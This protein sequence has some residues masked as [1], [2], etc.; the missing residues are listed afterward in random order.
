MN[1][2]PFIHT[3]L[4]EMTWLDDL[5]W[6]AAFLVLSIGAFLLVRWVFVFTARKLAARTRTRFDDL[7]VEKGVVSAVALFAPAIVIRQ[8]R[9]FF[10]DVA[11]PVGQGLTLYAMFVGVLLL[12]R[13]L[14][15]TNAFY[16]TFP[17]ARRRPIRGPV[18]LIKLFLYLITAVAAA[19]F[20]LGKS[21]WAVVSGI[22]AMTALVILIFKDTILSFVA[23]IQMAAYD[24]LRLG[25]WVEMPSFGADGDVID[26]SLNTVQVQNFDKTV[27]SIPAHKF[28]DHSFRNWRGM[29]E[30]GGRRIKRAILIDQSSI[31]FVN[32]EMQ[33]SFERMERI[34]EYMRTRKR[35]I[36]EH[37]AYEETDTTVAVNG[38]RMTNLG[39]FRA[40]VTAYLREN[41]KLRQDLTFM[42]RHLAP[43]PEGLPLEVYVFAAD[44]V[45]VN[46][47][48]IQADIFEHLMAALPFFELRVYQRVAQPDGRVST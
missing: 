44:T 39:C 1:E 36:D 14:S 23:G 2:L 41:L 31:R 8:A 40:Y 10:P 28:L 48:A 37:N 3:P 22:G 21:P 47:E 12:G 27:V 17:V 4:A 16:E 33:A 11:G 35:E 29:Q 20:L 5:L 13:M 24:L 18:Q 7:L 42:V 15:A 32:E 9:E 38:R 43:T 6:L 45:W 34:A 26:I 46:Y 19:A 25:D 30:A